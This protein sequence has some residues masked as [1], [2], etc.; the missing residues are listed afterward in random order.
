LIG[1]TLGD[2]PLHGIVR[3]AVT[4]GAHAGRIGRRQFESPA[5]KKVGAKKARPS[6]VGRALV[7]L[8]TSNLCCSLKFNERQRSSSKIHGFHPLR[9][10]FSPLC[11]LLSGH[12]AYLPS[13]QESD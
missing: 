5:A 11:R 2:Q 13:C 3:V 10:D 8:L 1:L 6:G 9:I 4:R 12:P 7:K